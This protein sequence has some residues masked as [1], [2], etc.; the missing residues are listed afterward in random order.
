MPRLAPLHL[1]A[2]HNALRELRDPDSV[3]LRLDALLLLA[4]A[5]R[6]AASDTRPSAALCAA[7]ARERPHVTLPSARAAAAAAAAAGLTRA[8]G[9]PLRVRS[10][11]C[12]RAHAA[13]VSQ[14]GALLCWGANARG[15]LG[16][17]DREAR[18]TPC[19][20]TLRAPVV[21]VACGAA[22]SAAVTAAGRVYAWGCNARGQ[23]ALGALTPADSAVPRRARLPDAASATALACGAQHLL[24]RCDNGALFAAGDNQ[25]GQLGLA[26][27]APLVAHLVHLR[28]TGATLLV[29]EVAAGDAQ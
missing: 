18:A 15:Q 22:F 27:A 26:D 21:R 10:V 20:V 7:L 24:V 6:R 8:P 14:R 1:L 4:A 11:A 28:G 23:L 3:A 19:V 25:H 9:A 13:A 29:A 5:L 17:G 12:G 16:L 2:L